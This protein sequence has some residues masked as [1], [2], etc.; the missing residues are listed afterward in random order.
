MAMLYVRD[1]TQAA[2]YTYQSAATPTDN[3]DLANQ[4]NSYGAQNYAY[5]NGIYVNA[6]HC[7]G[8]WLCASLE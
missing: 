4:A 2:V 7:T 6:S 8:D 1:T 5:Y 3:A